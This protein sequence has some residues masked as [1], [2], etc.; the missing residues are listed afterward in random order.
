MKHNKLSTLSYVKRRLKD[1]GFI[2]HVVLSKFPQHDSRKWT[3]LVDP[4]NTATF[5]T[6]YVNRDSVGDVSFVFDDGGRVFRRDM[7][8]KTD[9]M[10]VLISKLVNG[11]VQQ[12]N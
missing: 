1:S 5:I 8:I 7:F 3:L 2:T 11:N 9:S 12:T 10:E 4:H 6:C